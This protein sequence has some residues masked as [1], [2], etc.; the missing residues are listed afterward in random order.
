MRPWPSPCPPRPKK[1][2]RRPT[3][4][5][6]P[7]RPPTATPPRRR[8][9]RADWRRPA[10]EEHPADHPR[11]LQTGAILTPAAMHSSLPA[12]SVFL[13][14]TPRAK[15]R[16]TGADRLRFL[17]G[18]V[19]N[20]V[21]DATRGRVGLH[22]RDDDQRQDERRRLHP[23]RGR[24]PVARRRGRTARNARRAPGTL[25]HRGRRAD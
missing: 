14:L 5:T 9:A 11:L 18:Q 1:A 4:P 19:S 8:R 23:R 17:N 12:E 24:F 10:Q 22:G 20:D 15:L 7:L 3:F 25:H 2:R 21:R 16:V 13:D 6:F